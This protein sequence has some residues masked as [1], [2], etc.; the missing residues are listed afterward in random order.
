MLSISIMQQEL[1]KLFYEQIA[2]EELVSRL[3][4]WLY[5]R[6]QLYSPIS[7]AFRCSPDGREHCRTTAV[8]VTAHQLCFVTGTRRWNWQR[9][10]FYT[11]SHSAIFYWPPGSCCC[12]APSTRLSAAATKSSEREKS[13]PS[14]IGFAFVARLACHSSRCCCHPKTG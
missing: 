2:S 6:W 4:D 7:C 11:S 3:T 13:L 12:V 1:W 5:G 9:W 14:S 8:A 10:H